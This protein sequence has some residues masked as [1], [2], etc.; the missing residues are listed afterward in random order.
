M[1]QITVRE[2]WAT[3]WQVRRR[4]RLDRRVVTDLS[5][6]DDKTFTSDD[7][8]DR[9]VFDL[10]RSIALA[11]KHSTAQHNTYCYNVFNTDSY[12]LT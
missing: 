3:C 2:D 6:E 10:L 1:K 5:G 9:D 4:P 12:L 11:A 7:R 8:L